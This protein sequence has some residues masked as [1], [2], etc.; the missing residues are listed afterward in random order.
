MTTSGERA[1]P[2]GT[3]ADPDMTGV[4]PVGT[5]AT[6][7]LADQADPVGTTGNSRSPMID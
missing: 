2:D 6:A 1:D 7:D 3:A 5:T 4:D